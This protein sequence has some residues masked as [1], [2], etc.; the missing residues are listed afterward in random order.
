[1]AF[2]SLRWLKV[3]HEKLRNK[4]WKRHIPPVRPT[5]C[6]KAISEKLYSAVA[7]CLSVCLSFVRPSICLSAG[8]TVCR[9]VS[10]T[11]VLRVGLSLGWSVCPP[12]CLRAGLSVSQTVCLS[13]S[14][15]LVCLV[16]PMFLCLTVCPCSDAGP[17]IFDF[18][19]A[20][21]I[22]KTGGKCRRGLDKW[23]TTFAYR[24]AAALSQ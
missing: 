19:H 13:I 12:N 20:S 8:V 22:W 1:M 5:K 14:D 15:S 23:V 3:F 4:Q 24:T 9:P 6:S 17:S 16:C 2:V 11:A 10:E 21:E 7:L 18:E